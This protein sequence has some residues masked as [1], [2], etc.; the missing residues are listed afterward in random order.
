MSFTIVYD[1]RE[2]GAWS[3]ANRDRNLWGKRFTEAYFLDNNHVALTFHP[4]PDQSWRAWE[5]IR[6]SWILEW[7]A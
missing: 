1:L 4:S 6:K 3:N 2:V 7:A 5:E